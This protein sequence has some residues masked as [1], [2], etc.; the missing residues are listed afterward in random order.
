MG[1]LRLST[2]HLWLKLTNSLG[3]SVAFY[4]TWWRMLG[5]WAGWHHTSDDEVYS[6][7]TFEIQQ[8]MSE[9]VKNLSWMTQTKPA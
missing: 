8:D 6:A 7:H 4:P 3:L 9:M 2:G 5:V 1:P